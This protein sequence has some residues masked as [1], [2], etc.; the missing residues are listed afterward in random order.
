M[1]ALDLDLIEAASEND[2]VIGR[3]KEE[4]IGARDGIDVWDVLHVGCSSL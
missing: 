2:E 4:F 1:T 3:S